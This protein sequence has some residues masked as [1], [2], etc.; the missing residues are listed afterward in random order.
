VQS[1]SYASSLNLRTA[2]FLPAFV[3]KPLHYLSGDAGLRVSGFGASEGH[4]ANS[5]DGGGTG[6]QARHD[7]VAQWA[8]C[9]RLARAQR[10]ERTNLHAGQT[11]LDPL[12]ASQAPGVPKGWTA[13]RNGY[14]RINLDSLFGGVVCC[15]RRVASSGLQR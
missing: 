7:D 10:P 1:R 12:L 5:P 2:K 11:V 6:S 8:L 3:S 9:T 15:Q 13:T 4:Q 14:R